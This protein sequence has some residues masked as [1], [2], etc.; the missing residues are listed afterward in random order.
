M[1]HSKG[2]RYKKPPWK[3]KTVKLSKSTSDV[4]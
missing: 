1:G 3:T 4:G 2:K